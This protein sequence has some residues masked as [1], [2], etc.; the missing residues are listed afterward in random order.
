MEWKLKVPKICHFYWGGDILSY[1]RY[2]S[3][4]SFIKQNPDWQVILWVPKYPSVK[5]SWT[6]NQLSYDV[7]CEDFVPKL[8][9][10]PITIN[11]I[12]IEPLGLPNSISEL[13]K[14]DLVCYFLL[15]TYGGVWADMDILFFKPMTELAVNNPENINKETFV[16]ISHYG[17]SNGLLMSAGNN[18][19]FQKLTG[20]C[21]DNFDPMGYQSIGPTMVNKYFPKFE[22][23]DKLTPAVN[24]DMDAVY[25]HNAQ[26][27]SD[28]VSGVPPRFTEK[29]IGIHWYAG[30]P[31]W[32]KF[33]QETNGGQTNLPNNIIGNVLKSL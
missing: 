20:Y 15:A 24:I 22:D 13:H 19:F 21:R 7:Q 26:H 4:P 32:G 14:S 9:D 5:R 17:H 1:M 29:S 11:E 2:M 23:V 18:P 6:S 30:H 8:K 27:I 16:C 31:L 12:D 33:I 25:A 28:I 10:L 3:I